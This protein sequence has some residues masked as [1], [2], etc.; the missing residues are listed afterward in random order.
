MRS[1]IW[2]GAIAALTAVGVSASVAPPRPTECVLEVAPI[3][4][5]PLS[6]A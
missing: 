5:Q 2:G 3:T 6:W 4:P 1:L